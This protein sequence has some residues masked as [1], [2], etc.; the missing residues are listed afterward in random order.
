MDYKRVRVEFPLS[1]A[2]VPVV[3]KKTS[4]YGT[5]KFAVRYENIPHFFFVCRRIGHA[6][7]ECPEELDREAGVKF[8][9]ALRCSPRK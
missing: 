7:R 5:M 4:E 9:K 2:I 3:S 8:G 1:K 6:E